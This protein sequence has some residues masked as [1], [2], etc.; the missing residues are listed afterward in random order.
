MRRRSFLKAAM[1]AGAALVVP[2]P[3]ETK[4]VYFPLGEFHP[5]ALVLESPP[6]KTW[7][8]L[9]VVDGYEV[10]LDARAVVYTGK[11]GNHT[12][13]ELFYLLQPQKG[14]DCVGFVDPRHE[15]AEGW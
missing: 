13:P 5:T 12:M 8:D 10:D 15:M 14:Y 9:P 2:T 1:A 3:V 4:N 7:V 11:S 6:L